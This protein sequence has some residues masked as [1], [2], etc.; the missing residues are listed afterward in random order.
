MNTELHFS[1][2]KDDWQTPDSVYLPL[3]EEFKF[4]IDLAANSANRKRYLFLGPGALSV[5]NDALAIDW[6]DLPGPGWLNPPYSRG[7]QKRFVEK[8]A[9]ERLYGY[10]TVMLLPAR[11]DT[12]HFH[13]YIWDRERN[14][15]RP[16][17]EVR[18]VRG[19]IKFVGAKHAAPFPSMIVVFQGTNENR[20]RV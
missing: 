14:Q 12:A 7:L 8:A 2:G 10:T 1:S 19:R 16:G 17:I 4:R 20:L 9:L 18:F 15:P 11:P 6:R 3:D 13:K 5:C